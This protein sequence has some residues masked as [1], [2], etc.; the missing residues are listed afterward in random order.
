MKIVSQIGSQDQ[1]KKFLFQLEDG[2]TI[3]SVLLPRKLKQKKGLKLWA[4][5]PNDA[6]SELNASKLQERITLCVSSQVG[7]AMGC[8][9]C[10]TGTL[11]L[12]RNLS[13][14]EI[15]D[16]VR[17]VSKEIQKKITNIVF[18]GMGEPLHNLGAVIPAIEELKRNPEFG[19]SRR[20]ITVSTS[21]LVPQL[22][23]LARTRVK[24]AVSLNATTD[25]V[26]TQIMPVNGAYS[27]EVLIQ[28]SKEYAVSVGLPVMLEYVLLDGVNNSAEDL[29]RL[30]QLASGWS[31]KVNL[32]PYNSAGEM[33][34]K[35][36]LT[37]VRPTEQ[38][39]K[40]FQHGLVSNGITA[41]VRYSGGDDVGAAC[42]QLAAKT[43]EKLT[44]PAVTFN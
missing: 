38:S 25:P 22:K 24:L 5:Q 26:R 30:K 41:T 19:L 10:V 31:C 13:T 4:D 20:K 11:G 23:E 34:L 9:F 40:A 28:A 6:S 7:C 27:I 3:E 42:G 44:S 32:I 36:G 17:L 21:G 39:V 33:K 43:D 1:S 14:E 37:F 29:E 16:Q 12:K 35:E 18:M 8:R 2:L 15:L